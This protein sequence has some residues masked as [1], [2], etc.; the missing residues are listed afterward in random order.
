MN[1]LE[2]RRFSLVFR[3][4]DTGIRKTDLQVITDLNLSLRVGEIHAVVGSSGSG[5]SLSCTAGD[6]HTTSKAARFSAKNA[7][8]MVQPNAN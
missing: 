7:R 8:S 4:Y 2:I 1:S 5:K 3:M 6:A